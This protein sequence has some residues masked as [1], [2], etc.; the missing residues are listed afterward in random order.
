MTHFFYAEHLIKKRAAFTV[1][2][3]MAVPKGT[4]TVIVG[5]S[6]SGKSTILRLI[7]GLETADSPATRIML[8]GT[9]ITS[10][11]PGRRRVGMV[12]QQTALFPN[13]SVKD[14]VA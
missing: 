6:G 5:S 4:M 2:V 14:N 12:F 10:C 1:D 8:A 11:A 3:T 13:L 9:D 7:A